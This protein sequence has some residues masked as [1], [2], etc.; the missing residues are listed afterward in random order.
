MAKAKQETEVAGG[1]V[2]T[3][4][5][6]LVVTE[7]SGLKVKRRYEP[8]DAV[9]LPGNYKP[10]AEAQAR[11]GP[12]NAGTAFAVEYVITYVNERHEEVTEL[13]SRT[14]ILPVAEQAVEADA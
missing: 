1:Y 11:L 10:D 2:A 12:A 13:T 3:K 6:E 14:A 4:P 9:E 7:A 8:G 5:F